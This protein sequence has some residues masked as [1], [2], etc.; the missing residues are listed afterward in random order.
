MSKQSCPAASLQVSPNSPVIC[1]T[2][3]SLSGS[4]F[5]IEMLEPKNSSVSPAPRSL[6]SIKMVELF[7]TPYDVRGLSSQ[8]Y[9]PPLP[10]YIFCWEGWMPNFTCTK[11]FMR[12]IGRDKSYLIVIVEVFVIRIKSCDSLILVSLPKTHSIV[13]GKA[14]SLQNGQHCEGNEFLLNSHYLAWKV[15]LEI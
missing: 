14:G 4:S 1:V 13:H 7:T 6:M 12:P 2:E 8:M 11:C 3:I 9:L 10:Q 15:S 5:E